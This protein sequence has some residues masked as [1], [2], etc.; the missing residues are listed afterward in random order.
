MLQG[1]MIAKTVAV[2]PFRCGTIPTKYRKP[3]A[4][5]NT[6]ER[7]PG[8]AEASGDSTAAVGDF[9]SGSRITAEAVAVTR[10]HGCNA[11]ESSRI[12]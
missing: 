6:S 9:A 4:G 10:E 3:C 1:L 11:A 7:S 8:T 12:A 2:Q 5:S